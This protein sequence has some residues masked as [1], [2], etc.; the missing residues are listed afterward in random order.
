MIYK[1]GFVRWQFMYSVL[2]TFFWHQIG[3]HFRAVSDRILVGLLPSYIG[4][5]GTDNAMHPPKYLIC[6][7]ISP[8]YVVVYPI[9]TVTPYG[10]TTYAVICQHSSC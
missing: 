5:L 8:F 4:D 3:V 6:L 10:L 1:Y 9:C 2:Y 7:S